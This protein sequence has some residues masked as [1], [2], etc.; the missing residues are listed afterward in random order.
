MTKKITF[1]VQCYCVSSRFQRRKTGWIGFW[2]AEYSTL[3]AARKDASKRLPRTT[4]WN[5]VRVAKKVYYD[6]QVV[7]VPVK[8]AAA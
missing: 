4:R 8:E 1:E 3:A 2:N 5:G 7:T 6:D